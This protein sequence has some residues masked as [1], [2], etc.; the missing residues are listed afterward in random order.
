MG[1]LGGAGRDSLAPLGLEP[2]NPAGQ[3]PASCPTVN[4]EKVLVSFQRQPV[5]A[6][7]VQLFCSMRTNSCHGWVSFY[8]HHPQAPHLSMS[9]S[10]CGKVD[11]FRSAVLKCKD[12]RNTSGQW[13]SVVQWQCQLDNVWNLWHRSHHLTQTL[14]LV[15]FIF[16]WVCVKNYHFARYMAWGS[17]VNWTTQPEYLLTPWQHVTLCSRY[18]RLGQRD[19]SWFAALAY[20]YVRLTF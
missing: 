10:L 5:N 2:T 17:I 11:L 19:L 20:R 8:G 13:P 1:K 6:F 16:P 7:S 4:T 12:I 3:S 9:T 14:T 18:A 15:Y